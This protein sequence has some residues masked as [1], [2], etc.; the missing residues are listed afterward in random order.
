VYSRYSWIVRT[1]G[2]LF[3]VLVT[4]GAAAQTPQPQPGDIGVY[5]DAAGT[6]SQGSTQDFVPFDVYVVGFEMGDAQAFEYGLQIP[7]QATIVSSEL[8]D[9]ATPPTPTNV[10]YALAECLPAVGAVPLQRLQLGFFAPGSGSASDMTICLTL[11]RPSTLAQWPSWEACSG[12]RRAFGV[13]QIGDGSYPDGCLVLNKYPPVYCPAT[14]FELVLKDALVPPGA[15]AALAYGLNEFTVPFHFGASAA[16]DQQSCDGFDGTGLS[17]D[18][19]YDPSVLGW[20]GA[21]G[22][23]IAGLPV[24]SSELSPGHVHVDVGSAADVAFSGSVSDFGITALGKLSFAM[25]AEGGTTE[26]FARNIRVEDRDD[27]IERLASDHSVLISSDPAVA[28]ESLRV[29]AL[30]ARY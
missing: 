16:S 3:W 20:A 9:G 8:I 18:L 15:S 12:T 29:G 7:S 13:A 23:A 28:T 26:L 11:S 4:A 5:M 17:F 6:Q 25:R 14:R 10:I 22:S 30:K 2:T 24:V 27:G 1:L 21:D 19:D